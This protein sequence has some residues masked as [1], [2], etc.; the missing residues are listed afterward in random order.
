MGFSLTSLSNRSLGTGSR[1]QVGHM[2]LGEF[3]RGQRGIAAEVYFHFSRLGACSSPMSSSNLLSRACRFQVC[4]LWRSK[5]SVMDGNVSLFFVFFSRETH[6][7]A[8]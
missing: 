5:P 7:G 6:S 8:G 3:G 2:G 1:R 4:A